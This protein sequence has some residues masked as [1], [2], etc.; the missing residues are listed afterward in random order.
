[1]SVLDSVHS[2][3][4]YGVVARFR[5]VVVPV[6]AIVLLSL[7]SLETV[8]YSDC[9]NLPSRLTQSASQPASGNHSGDGC[10]CCCSHIVI[11]PAVHIQPMTIVAPAADPQ[12]TDVPIARH[13]SVFHPPRA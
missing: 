4:D 7:V 8:F 5:S 12:P 3:G 6:V 1:M 11:T 9:S 2:I 10:L 13:S